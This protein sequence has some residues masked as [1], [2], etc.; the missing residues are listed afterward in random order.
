MSLYVHTGGLNPD[1]FIHTLVMMDQR[2]AHCVWRIKFI[3]VQEDVRVMVGDFN[4]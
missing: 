3:K 1:S 2:T 4:S